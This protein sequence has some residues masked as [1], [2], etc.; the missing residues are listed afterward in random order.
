MRCSIW[1]LKKYAIV[2]D[3]CV[4]NISCVQTQRDIPDK[5]DQPIYS[6]VFLWLFATIIKASRASSRNLN[7]N[8]IVDVKLRETVISRSRIVLPAVAKRTIVIFHDISI[9]DIEEWT[10]IE[11]VIMWFVEKVFNFIAIITHDAS[12]NRTWLQSFARM[13]YINLE[14]KF[15]VHNDNELIEFLQLSNWRIK[16]EQSK[17]VVSYATKVK[18]LMMASFKVYL[19]SCSVLYF[20]FSFQFD[21][22]MLF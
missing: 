8:R 19:S 6:C 3:K 5:S 9:I 2:Y 21:I 4:N 15:N 11:I 14:K 18:V 10:P 17:W 20:I 13:I 7:R 12:F 22:D 1:A 16:N